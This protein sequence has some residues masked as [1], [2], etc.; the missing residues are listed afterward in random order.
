[1][2]VKFKATMVLA[3][4]MLTG[5]GGG[6]GSST[7]DPVTPPL[8]PTPPP[9][10]TAPTL[11]ISAADLTVDAG[12]DLEFDVTA[13]DSS[14]FD[15]TSVTCTE[16][17]V[18]TT[19]DTAGETQTVTATFG[20]PATAG[21]V[22]CTATSTD[23]AGNSANLDFTILVNP[24]PVVQADFNGTWFGPCFNNSSGFSFRQT[25]TIA[26]TSLVSAIESFA[27]GA[28]PAPNC[29]LP[30]GEGLVIDTDVTAS[31]DFQSDVGLAGCL[32]DRA[33]ATSVDILTVDTS[34]NPTATSEPEI[35]DTLN[36]VTGFT[37][38]LPSPSNICVLPNN[39]LLFAGVE[40][41]GDANTS[42][43]LPAF[44]T[45]SD[46]TWSLGDNNYTGG[47]S[48]SGESAD[49]NTGV[50]VVSTSNDT[51][52]GDFSGSAVTFSHT[53]RGSGVYQLT[54]TT[55]VATADPD[56]S[57]AKLLS[58]GASVGTGSGTFTTSYA[59]QEDDGFVIAVLDDEGRYHFS[60][61][62]LIILDRSIDVG[63]GV[64]DAPES[65][66]LEMTNLFDFDN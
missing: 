65:F 3:A 1:M 26:G 13:T 51:A 38:I 7:P 6:G 23:S 20:A 5:C 29:G 47:T 36:L 63:G 58:L 60:T 54:T 27:A 34:G 44:D 10:T 14:G 22:N 4:L 45:D 43:I 21:N 9:D 32:N 30:G 8:A 52:N 2:S 19:T 62:Q 41:T 46:V 35:S 15:S 66:V 56:D 57:N 12:Q 64:P 50:L 37:D 48:N 40:Y 53:L 11:E 49:G 17:E 39:N 28:T 24:L 31:L 42:V 25:L 33:V 16:G 61:D 55:E 59:T 18:T